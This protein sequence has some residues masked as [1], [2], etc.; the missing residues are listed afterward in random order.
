MD[1]PNQPVR[2]GRGTW[3]KRL[4][5]AGALAS[6]VL[7]AGCTKE[8]WEVGFLPVDS[9]GAT[10]HTEHYIALWN[11]GWIAA[12]A[13]GAVTWG[14]MLWCLVVYRRR[15]SDRGLPVQLQ[16]NMPIEILYTALPI[17][18]IMG[19]FFQTVHSL[20]HTIDDKTPGQE[21]IE[22]VGKQWSWDFNYMTENVHYAGVQANLDGTEAP[23]RNAP[24]LYLPA[25]RD[26]DLQLRSRD[27]IHS[28]WVPAFL[29]KR[30]MTPGRTEH[31]HF[32]PLKEGEYVG[33]CAEL[34]GEFHSEMLFNVKVV[35]YDEYKK[36]TAGLKAEGNEGRLG[37]EYDRTDWYQ[38]PHEQ[39]GAGE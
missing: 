33:K 36:Y 2:R 20:E 32:K 21:Q 19:F 26:I 10:S 29:E 30:D 6:T 5:V 24:T 17:V 34:C 4:G 39:K 28:F 35:S 23:G 37:P 16:Y 22:V 1:S 14:L 25:N 9:K 8:Q 11:G 38:N 15:K 12:L 31:I 3:A 13:V 18:L 27:V 7:L